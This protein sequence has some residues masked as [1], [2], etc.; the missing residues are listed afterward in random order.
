MLINIKHKK[1]LITIDFKI[2][3]IRYLNDFKNRGLIDFLDLNKDDI[4]AYNYLFIP[5]I[6]KPNKKHLK[7]FFNCLKEDLKNFLNKDIDIK[8]LK[9]INVVNPV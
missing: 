5:Y 4:E 2:K 3:Q 7:V 9:I 1:D 8:E 6:N